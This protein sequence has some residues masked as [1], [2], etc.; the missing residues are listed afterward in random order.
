M[1]SRDVYSLVGA[2]LVGT[3]LATRA[4]W[5]WWGWL[6]RRR[7]LAKVKFMAE[8]GQTKIN[9]W[10]VEHWLEIINQQTAQPIIARESMV[11]NFGGEEFLFAD[12]GIE[13]MAQG[14]GGPYYRLAPA[15][16]LVAVG[17]P[18][19]ELLSEDARTF[20][21]LTGT[22]ELAV[23]SIFRWADFAKMLTAEKRQ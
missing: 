14:K 22:S 20:H 21:R 3:L 6:L 5:M 10:S 19:V 7:F 4:I 12:G 16:L 23:F 11:L 17:R 13:Y 2:L 9:G 1:S 18:A 15:F 8:S